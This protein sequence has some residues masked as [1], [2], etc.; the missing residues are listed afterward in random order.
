MSCNVIVDPSAIAK[1]ETPPVLVSMSNADVMLPLNVHA[2]TCPSLLKAPPAPDVRLVVEDDFSGD[3][4]NT[5]LWNP[6]QQV[7]L[8]LG[9]LTVKLTEN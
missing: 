4:L 1:I 9:I 6:L 3:T 8:V 7:G 2:R 5:S